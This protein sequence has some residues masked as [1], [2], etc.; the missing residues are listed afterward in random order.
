ME[1]YSDRNV[2][3][4]SLIRSGMQ[5]MLRDSQAGRF[6]IVFSEAM[7]RLSR[8]QSDIAA[9]FERFQFQGVMIETL[10]EGLLSELHIGMK[11]TMNAIFLKDL[12]IKTRRGLMGRALAGKCAGGKAY[13]YKN[14]VKFTE[15]GDPIKDDC[16]IIPREAATINRIFTDYAHG[17]SPMK[18]AP[19]LNA[20]QIPGPT[21]R[22]WGPSMLHGS[23]DRGTGI[24]N[25]E[26]YVGAQV[27]NH[28]TYAK[29]PDTGKRASRLNAEADWV[30]SQAPQ[31]RIVEKALWDAV[32]AHQG[33]LKSKGTNTPSGTADDRG[34]C[35]QGF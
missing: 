32:R 21:G 8:S 2:S 3:G 14:L 26:L 7:D 34:H 16:A 20:E 22:G 12:G 25:N 4:A 27:W 23:R 10:S 29:D 11:G 13:G 17:I 30:T 18:I 28:L 31:L 33:A 9:I 15:A 35:F 6:D 5:K 24:L 1:E 19:A